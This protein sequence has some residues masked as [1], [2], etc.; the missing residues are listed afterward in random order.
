MDVSVEVKHRQGGHRPPFII[1]DN[2]HDIFTDS[3]P[4]IQTQINSI[5]LKRIHTDIA[6]GMG[7]FKI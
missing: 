1:H 2:Q 5:F 3:K 4:P 6:V 7:V